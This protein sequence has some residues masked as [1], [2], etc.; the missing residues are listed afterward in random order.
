MLFVLCS[1]RTILNDTASSSSE[2]WLW[3]P[4]LRQKD[5]FD[6]LYYVKVQGIIMKCITSIKKKKRLEK[7]A[8]SNFD[9]LKAKVRGIIMKCITSIKR[10]KVRSNFDSFKNSEKEKF[11]KNSNNLGINLEFRAVH[12]NYGFDFHDRFLFFIPN[13]SDEIPVVYSLGTSVNS[14]GKTH[15]LIQQTLDP[16][17]IVKA[18]QELWD[19][20]N[21]DES[22]IIKL[23]QVNKNA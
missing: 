6:T 18:F 20:L 9:S 17:N 19:L 23:P 3:D 13:N 11:I 4:F 16:R 14:L 21:N 12:K 15:H 8:R 22:L 5:I 1:L 2:I 10:K 7:E